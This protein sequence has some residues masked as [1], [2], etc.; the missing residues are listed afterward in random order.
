MKVQYIWYVHYEMVELGLW[1]ISK[2]YVIDKPV[3]TDY[4][5]EISKVV[6]LILS[7]WF[8]DLVSS[9]LTS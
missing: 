1:S 8:K 6:L 4:C 2:N 9:D 5:K 3:F 7:N